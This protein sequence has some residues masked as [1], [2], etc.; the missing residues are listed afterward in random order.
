MKVKDIMTTHPVCCTP[1]TPLSAVARM[2]LENDCGAI[3]VIENRQSMNPLGMLTDRDITCRT[4]AAGKNPLELTAADCM[5]PRCISARPEDDLEDCEDLMMEHQ[6]RRIIVT[7][8]NGRCCGI[9]TQAHIAKYAS[10]VEAAGVLKEIS[11][12]SHEARM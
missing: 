5:T 6:V 3:P 4:V 8:R 10:D 7:D 11:Q 12:P 9:V 2:M 1:D